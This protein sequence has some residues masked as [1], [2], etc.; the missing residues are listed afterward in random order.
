MHALSWPW[1]PHTHHSHTHACA[2]TPTLTHT[3]TCSHSLT[4]GHIAHS[5]SHS[6][7]HNDMLTIVVHL[8][9]LLLCSLTMYKLG[10]FPVVVIA[11][12][13]V[14][15]STPPIQ[16]LHAYVNPLMIEWNWLAHCFLHTIFFAEYTDSSVW[17]AKCV[18]HRC[19]GQ[20][21]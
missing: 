11:V 15:D 13:V 6:R 18:G 8:S 4:H 2:L 21:I 17:W 7:S 3:R 12:I 1:H 9:L 5:C 10:G 16:L 19:Y 14:I 20:Y